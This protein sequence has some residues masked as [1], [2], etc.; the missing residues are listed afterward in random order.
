MFQAF[1]VKLLFGSHSNHIKLF[2]PMNHILLSQDGYNMA[3]K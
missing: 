3:A 1:S 2:F